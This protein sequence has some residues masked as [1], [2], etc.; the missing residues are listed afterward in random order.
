MKDIENII[1]E[2]Y[3]DVD[4]FCKAFEDYCIKNILSSDKVNKVFPKCMMSL[5]EVITITILFH[6]SGTRCFK[7]FYAKDV[8]G[9]NL[10][11][12]F[13]NRLSYGRFVE[14]MQY[15]IL[16]LL[17][18]TLKYKCG[19][20]TGI[21]Y[22]DSTFLEA[23]HLRREY[24]HKVFKGI[25]G[26]GKGSTGWH[27]GFKL[28]LIINEKGEI[29]SF[30][31]T[32]GN[33]DDRNMDVINHLCKEISGKLFG[34]RGYVSKKLFEYLYENKGIELITKLK[35]NMKNK[36]M[37]IED[38]ILLRKRLVIES[39]NDFLKNICYIEHSRHRSEIN[40]YINVISGLA[41]YSFLEKLP[42]LH[43]REKM[44]LNSGN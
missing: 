33:V 42:S 43:L 26:K 17:V 21:S 18:Y 23:C 31:L 2:I 6:H 16:P 38:K 39:V 10:R 4:E 29:I 27:Y 7:W 37:N 11:E 44:G 1:T 34:D 12:Y 36:L 25:A 8:C 32:A 41:A 28:H 35:K 40:F 15:A 5:S 13:P 30:C 9:K 14:V 3:Y 24:S 19:D 22:I 20:S